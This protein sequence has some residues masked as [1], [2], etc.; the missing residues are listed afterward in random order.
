MRWRNG[1]PLIQRGNVFKVSKN[2]TPI[3]TTENS[4]IVITKK[5]SKTHANLK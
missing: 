4:T 3:G 2:R 5:V 1:I